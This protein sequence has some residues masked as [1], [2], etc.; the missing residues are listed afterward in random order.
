VGAIGVILVLLTIGSAMT[1]AFKAV[2]A[3]SR[4]ASMVFRGL[5]G[6]VIGSCALHLGTAA[7]IP[8]MIWLGMTMAAPGFLYNAAPL[9]YRRLRM[10]AANRRI[11]EQYAGPMVRMD[12]R[13]LGLS[14]NNP[15][16]RPGGAGAG[17][18]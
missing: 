10:A 15:L 5:V 4:G 17:F 11:A 13:P 18:S 16:G 3:S 12:R 14:R 2:R 8:M 7:L 1:G 9:D 6:A